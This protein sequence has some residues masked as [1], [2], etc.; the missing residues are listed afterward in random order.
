MEVARGGATRVL[1]DDR[2]GLTLLAHAGKGNDRELWRGR[3]G[4]AVVYEYEDEQGR[5]VQQV[6]LETDRA[7]AVRRLRH[8][9]CAHAARI[10]A[11]GVGASEY[12]FDAS[13]RR[14]LRAVLGELS[15]TPQGHALSG[16]I[17]AVNFCVDAPARC[18]P[19]R[20]PAPPGCD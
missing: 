7:E 3:P 5:P 12:A 4:L 15:D 11:S 20:A 14:A 17:N 9:V 10:R 13:M 16:F 1:Y 6:I 2:T 8:L 19:L 18:P